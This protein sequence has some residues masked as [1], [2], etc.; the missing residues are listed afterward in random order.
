MEPSPTCLGLRA[1]FCITCHLLHTLL[2]PDSIT[3]SCAVLR[4]LVATLDAPW[5]APLP[6]GALGTLLRK[7]AMA[8]TTMVVGSAADRQGPWAGSVTCLGSDVLPVGQE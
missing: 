5:Q 1:Q 2:E 8:R 6:R 7:G 3:A 4:A